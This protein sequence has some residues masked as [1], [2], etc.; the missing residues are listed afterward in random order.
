MNLR[1]FDAVCGRLPAATLSI[2]WGEAHVW[3]IGGK[4]FALAS[5]HRKP[6]AC[7]LKASDIAREALAGRRGVTPAPY[8][9][10]AG[11]LSIEDGAMPDADI[12]DMLRAAHALV[13]AALPKKMRAALFAGAC[14]PPPRRARER[15]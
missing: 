7:S 5:P 8:L 10:R 4:I 3:K 1:R 14:P 9:A 6:F 13:A 2:Q 11:W 12:A 15:R